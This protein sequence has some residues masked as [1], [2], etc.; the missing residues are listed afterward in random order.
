MHVGQVVILRRYVPA[1]I[2]SVLFVIPY[3][4]VLFR[5][6]IQEGTVDISALFFYFVIA[7]PLTIP[8]ILI[9]HFLGDFLYRKTVKLLVG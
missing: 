5:R 1:V 3:G 8:F 4:F 2:S 9:M 6:L 7:I